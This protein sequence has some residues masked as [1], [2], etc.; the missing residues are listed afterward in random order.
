MPLKLVKAFR[1][2]FIRWDDPEGKWNSADGLPSPSQ[3]EVFNIE[4]TGPDIHRL[5]DEEYRLRWPRP[6]P[7]EYVE[8]GI[9]LNSLTPEEELA[10]FLAARAYCLIRNGRIADGLAAMNWLSRLSPHNSLRKR[11]LD[12]LT[13]YLQVLRRGPYLN[14]PLETMFSG[15]ARVFGPRWIDTNDGYKAIV[16]ILAPEYMSPMGA[17]RPPA[18]A[19]LPMQ[20]QSVNL[21]NGQRAWAEVPLQSS[22]QPLVAYWIQLSLNEFALVHKRTMT[23][24]HR[25]PDADREGQPVLPEPRQQSWGVATHIPVAYQSGLRGQPVEHQALLRW[26]E[27][28][29]KLA[30]EQ[31]KE[32]AAGVTGHKRELLAQFA[33]VIGFVP[34]HAH[35]PPVP[36]QRTPLLLFQP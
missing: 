11:E 2:L 3:G 22:F 4:A 26:E 1:H 8:A 33:P 18:N 30:I 6:I 31:M 10:E 28:T 21:P 24:L 16:Q 25:P 34:S 5:S 15:Q 35:L 14:Q 13:A 9:Y 36:G 20:R 32:E 17:C 27:S 7:T 23:A 12:H 19:G 29:I